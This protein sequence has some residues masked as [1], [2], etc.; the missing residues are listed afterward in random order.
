MRTLLVL[1]VLSVLFAGCVSLEV[2]EIISD[3]GHKQVTIRYDMRQLYYM[4]QGMSDENSTTDL[5]EDLDEGVPGMKDVSCTHEN[6]LAI[7]TGTMDMDDDVFQAHKNM[8]FSTY[9]YNP[10]GG[11][12]YLDE[13]ADQDLEEPLQ[14]NQYMNLMGASFTYK[15]QMPGQVISTT[16]GTIEKDTVTIDLLSVGASE[17]IKI[18]AREYNYYGIIILGTISIIIMVM[19]ITLFFMKKRHS[20]KQAS[21]E[22]ISISEESLNIDDA[23]GVE[24]ERNT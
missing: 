4:M 13:M 17:Q 21:K 5:C 22:D 8:F 2:Q 3:E 16:H 19:I 7:V 10:S 18:V 11:L 24:D 15:V 14:G 23:K 6:G 12:S 9:N 20:Y 1:L